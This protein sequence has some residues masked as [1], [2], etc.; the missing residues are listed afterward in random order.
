MYVFESIY[1]LDQGWEILRKGT[2]NGDLEKKG[3]M[4]N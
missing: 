2:T 3:W 4:V 1:S